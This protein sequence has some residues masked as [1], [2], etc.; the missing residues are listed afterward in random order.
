MS[1]LNEDKPEPSFWL[2]LLV[3]AVAAFLVTSILMFL[4]QVEK[5]TT[6][7]RTNSPYIKVIQVAGLTKDYEYITAE[8]TVMF[9]RPKYSTVR[10]NEGIVYIVREVLKRHPCADGNLMVALDQLQEIK[11]PHYHIEDA[12]FTCGE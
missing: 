12:K 2:G 11:A 10:E 8:V 1:L 3:G 4:Y 6:F 7:L 9:D 5:E